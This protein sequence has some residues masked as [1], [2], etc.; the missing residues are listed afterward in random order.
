LNGQATDTFRVRIARHRPG[1][2][3][4]LLLH[5]FKQLYWAAEIKSGLAETVFPVPLSEIPDGV[6]A[7]TLLDEENRPAAERLVM[8]SGHGPVFRIHAPKQKFSPRDSISVSLQWSGMDSAATGTFSVSCAEVGRLP[9]DLTG[10]LLDTWFLGDR[11]D[12]P[13][14][15]QL[16]LFREGAPD[17]EK[18]DALLLTRG[19]RR[20][21]WEETATPPERPGPTSLLPGRGR[22]IAGKKKKGPFELVIFNPAQLKVVSTDSSGDFE[23]PV[24]ELVNDT[25]RKLF[26][27][28]YKNKREFLQIWLDT[29]PEHILNKRGDWPVPALSSRVKTEYAFNDQYM[30]LPFGMKVLEEVVVGGKRTEKFISKDCRDYICHN[31]VLNCEVHPQGRGIPITGEIYTYRFRPGDPPQQVEYVGCE[32]VIA[33][34]PRD[35]IAIPGINV[36]KE[37]YVPDLSKSSPDVPEY[38]TTLYWNPR[39]QLRAG[40][41]VRPSF[42]SSDW[43]GRFR[44]TVEGI[45]PAGPV[46]AEQEFVV[47]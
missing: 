45:T 34:P 8:R 33:Q 23:I 1:L 26:L 44:I 5:N 25:R 6:Y 4:K 32:G 35:F 7:F 28:P 36:A 15:N 24:E 41:I 37:F 14:F 21:R 31:Y 12:R 46:H 20:Y 38:H 2:R 17:P 13:L 19:W 11:F 16:Q 30:E 40:E 9:A 22:V 18:L 10:N 3:V 43:K 42:Y 29:L 27:A 47:E 39:L